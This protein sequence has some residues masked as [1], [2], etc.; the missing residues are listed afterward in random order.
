MVGRFNYF[1][2]KGFE[3]KIGTRLDL[4]FLGELRQPG[5]RGSRGSRLSTGRMDM[6]SEADVEIHRTGCV[7]DAGKVLENEL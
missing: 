5:P 1:E 3:K 4:W 7:R 6:K 2:T